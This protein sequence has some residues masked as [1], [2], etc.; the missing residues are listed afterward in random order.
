MAE[1]KKNQELPKHL[2][3]IKEKLLERKNELE[4]QLSELYMSKETPDAVQDPGDHAQSL[5]LETLKISL[6]DTELEEYNRIKQAISM[7]DQG[8]YGICVDCEQPIAE[9]RLKLYPNATRCLV[10]QELLEEQKGRE[11]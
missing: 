10:C 4:E 7:I 8:I 6:Q 1:A 2:R 5:S 11:F 9:K 3:A